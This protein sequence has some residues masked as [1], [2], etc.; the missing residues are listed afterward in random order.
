MKTT[1]AFLLLLIPVLSWCTDD[2]CGKNIHVPE[3]FNLKAM[4][5]ST[6]FKPE[7]SDSV[8]TEYSFVIM[9][10]F[11]EQV[12]STDIPEQGWNGLYHNR[13][14]NC[15]EG[16]YM[17]TLSFKANDSIQRGCHGFV[18]LVNTNT[19]VKVI[20]IDTIQ[21]QLS[22]YV[23]N[24]FTPNGDGTNDQFMAV[25]GCPP[26][27][28][29]MFIYDRWGDLIFQ[30][31]DPSVGWTGYTARGVPAQAD[32]YVWQLQFRYFPG[33]KKRKHVGHVTM[34]R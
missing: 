12:F 18:S 25:F 3:V 30:T 2:P 13:K 1:A 19:F 10:R 8:I 23:P 27:D 34:V 6:R 11:G 9:D 21:C 24:A 16:S 22:F 33:D 20:A 5:D 28:F 29:Q 14:T 26:V 7:L 32:V 17:W 15:A 4:T 31:N